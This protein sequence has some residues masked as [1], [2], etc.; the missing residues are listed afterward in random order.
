MTA[1][2]ALAERARGVAGAAGG[3][4][5]ADLHPNRYRRMIRQ[6]IDAGGTTV[7][8]DVDAAFSERHGGDD[9]PLARRRRLS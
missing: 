6:A 7:P 3:G 4:A 2:A 9:H 1:A 5:V 8:R